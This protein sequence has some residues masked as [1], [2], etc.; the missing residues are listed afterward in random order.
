MLDE[1]KT[2]LLRCLRN[3]SDDALPWELCKSVGSTPCGEVRVYSVRVE[4]E[5]A[6]VTKYKVVGRVPCAPQAAYESL[7]DFAQHRLVWDSTLSMGEVV[8]RFGDSGDGS[9][10]VVRYRTNPTAAGLVSGREF[11]DL[12]GME[13]LSGG[14]VLSYNCAA[15][16]AA[17]AA[18]GQE[19]AAGHVRATNFSGTGLHVVAEP[20]GEERVGSARDDEQ[21][22]RIFAEMAR[23][24]A[25][26]S[27]AVLS[28]VT[29]V[30]HTDPGGALPKWLVNRATSGALISILT[31]LQRY[32]IESCHRST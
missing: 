22:Q 28:R 26:G 12:H 17:T 32:C 4:G 20:A 25:P 7:C 9:F 18:D 23:E 29:M 13:R 27:H 30:C 6:A 8:Q 16:A 19:V 3:D 10:C 2:G 11:V 1:S 14:G 5:G 21:G 31:G 15:A 24:A